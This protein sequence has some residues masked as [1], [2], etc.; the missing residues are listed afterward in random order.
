MSLQQL[1]E[2]VIRQEEYE[3]DQRTAFA[4]ELHSEFMHSDRQYCTYCLEP[5]LEKQ[6]C[7][8]ENHW[9]T[10]AEL[11]EEDQEYLVEE[12]INFYDRWSRK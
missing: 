11:P 9:A 7:C 4:E 1:Y 2:T 10:Y 12:E 3:M 8:G 6:S 5:R